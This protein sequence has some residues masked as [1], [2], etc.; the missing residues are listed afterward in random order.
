MYLGAYLLRLAAVC[1]GAYSGVNYS[2]T[3]LNLSRTIYSQKA[4]IG[5]GI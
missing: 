5:G 3:G 4:R 1:V 2:D